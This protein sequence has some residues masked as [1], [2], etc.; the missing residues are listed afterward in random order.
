MNPR[1]DLLFSDHFLSPAELLV[2][3]PLIRE[4]LLI[5]VQILLTK[6][7]SHGHVQGILKVPEAVLA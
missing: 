3:L 1:I 2:L 4:F 6:T 7:L 5:R